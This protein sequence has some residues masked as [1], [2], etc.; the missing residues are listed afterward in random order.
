MRSA[1]KKLIHPKGVYPIRIGQKEI[2]DNVVQGV[3]GF[4]LLY[5]FI[6]IFLSL[7]IS[8]TANTNFISSLAVS[9]STIG[10]I[11]PGLGA[12]GP[13]Y[14]WGEFPNATKWIVS[15]GM[16]LGRL[17]IFTVIILFSRTYWKR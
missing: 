3:L 10:N 5:I 15:L 9:A 6:F 14:N 12:I 16:L 7:I 11:G 1:I 13:L 17:E 2:P 4:Y 8:I